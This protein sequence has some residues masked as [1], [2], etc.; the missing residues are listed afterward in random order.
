MMM[1]LSELCDI[2]MGQSPPS[3]YYNTSGQ[4]LPLLQG[5]RTFGLKYPTFDTYTTKV[6][7]IAEAG[8]VIM[9]VRAPVGDVNI[10]PIKVCLGR[11]VCALR[12]KENNQEFLYYLMRYYA[13]K[14]RNQES[15]TVFGAVTASDIRN[16]QIRVLAHSKQIE[17][18]ETCR[19]LDEKISNNMEIC[20][21]LKQL[22]H[23]IFQAWFVNFDAFSGQRPTAW[24]TKN[25]LDIATFLNGLTMQSYPPQSGE[26]GLPVLKIRE[27]RQGYFDDTST[28]CSSKIKPEYIVQ[29]GDVIFSWSG[30]LMLDIWCGDGCGLNQHLFKVT[31]TK[32]DPWFYYGWIEHHLRSFIDI[33][34]AS[35]TTIG[36]IKRKDLKHTK[37]VIPT[38]KEYQR[39]GAILTPLYA[40]I[41]NKRN[42]NHK[43]EKL[44]DLLLINQFECDSV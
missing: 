13:K 19:V 8:D 34:A 17:V 10:T 21:K 6:T 1:Q 27:L 30:T 5:N 29:N 7:K 35:A 16:L 42:E 25:L 39:V 9:S 28:R 3:Q 36:H 43:L 32:Y 24:Q 12:H 40:Q 14:L 31:S 11:G 33:A 41:I 20:S 18:S 22:S 37:V 44:R 38:P 23:T 26:A 4:G 2:K 15:G